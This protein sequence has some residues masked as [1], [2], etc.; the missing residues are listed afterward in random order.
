MLSV[1]QR[2]TV[3]R[4]IIAISAAALAIQSVLGGGCVRWNI[5]R[6]PAG[7]AV[8]REHVVSAPRNDPPVA[9]TLD[10][11]IT[12]I[13]GAPVTREKIP[14]WVDLQPGALMSAGTHQFKALV[15]PH[16]RPR[17]W[18]A[19]EVS[20]TATVESGKVYFLVD[21]EGAPALIEA[22]LGSR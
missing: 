13:D 12:E 5:D 4:R 10:F 16:L 17:D 11:T 15:A 6:A 3:K 8:V 7:F 21:R 19:K 9:S 1:G 22:H 14:P 18:R 2:E 20:F